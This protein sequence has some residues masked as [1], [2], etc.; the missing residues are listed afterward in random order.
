MK[1]VVMLFLW[2]ATGVANAQN[3]TFFADTDVDGFGDP[4]VFQVADCNTI[5]I[6]YVQNDLDCD[7]T[8]PYVNPDAIEVCNYIDDNCN[9]GEIDEFVLNNYYQDSDGDGYGD[10][11]F[12]AYDCVL[13]IGFVENMDDCDDNLI[14]YVDADGDGFGSNTMEP[15][16]ADNNLDCNDNSIAVQD[17]TTYY[18]DLDQDG[19]GNSSQFLVSCDYVMGYVLIGNDCDDLDLTINPNAIDEMGNGIDENCDGQDGVGVS[20]Q[21]MVFIVYPQPARNNVIIKGLQMGEQWFLYNDLGV[22]IR[23]GLTQENQ[24]T[25]SCHSLETGLY[26]FRSGEIQSSLMVE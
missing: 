12:V 18:Q 6:D 10:A 15:C 8:N 13:P 20:E 17:S 9:G 25:I 2:L 24:L 5:L 4:N 1:S 7:D 19:F 11:N 21:E 22:L 16:G 14:T 26:V 3:C 23:T